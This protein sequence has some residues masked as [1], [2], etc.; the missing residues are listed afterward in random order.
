MPAKGIEILLAAHAKMRLRDKIDL[1]LYGNCDPA[2]RAELE[3]R[4]P[5]GMKGY[6]GRFDAGGLGKVLAGI[7][8]GL[9]PSI[10]EETYGFVAVEFQ[11]AGIPVIASRTGGIPEIIRDGEN[12]L[13]VE[14]GDV[15]EL[16]RAMDRVAEEEG[17]IGFLGARAIRFGLFSAQIDSLEAIY[18]D[19]RSGAPPRISFQRQA[20]TGESGVLYRN[21][22]AAI[23]F[24]DRNLPPAESAVV[25]RLDAPDTPRLRQASAATF[26]PSP[27]SFAAADSNFYRASGRGSES[28]SVNQIQ[29]QSPRSAA[30]TAMKNPIAAPVFRSIAWIS[31]AGWSGYRSR[32]ASIAPSV[33]ALSTRMIRERGTVWRNSESTHSRSS[34]FRLMV[35]MTATTRVKVMPTFYYSSCLPCSAKSDPLPYR[36]E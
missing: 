34:F 4:F 18:R 17:L 13:L 35:G 14:P 10:C 24:G 15:E 2:Y 23:L 6:K 5:D 31:T 33:P 1:R 11:Q 19:L 36:R 32:T 28:S 9:F 30:S 7:D 3:R 27:D 26:F 12:G 22:S 25:K 16:S 21:D 20:S 8:A 29:S